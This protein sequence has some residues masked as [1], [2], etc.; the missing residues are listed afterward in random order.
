MIPVWTYIVSVVGLLVIIV[1]QAVIY[2]KK[3]RYWISKFCNARFAKMVAEGKLKRYE[4]AHAHR[5]KLKGKE[6]VE[7]RVWL[8]PK[9]HGDDYA[10][11]FKTLRQARA[12]MQGAKIAEGTKFWK[13]EEP[14]VVWKDGNVYYEARPDNL[15]A[16]AIDI[17]L[18]P[19]EHWAG[20]KKDGETK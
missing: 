13:V 19:N 5:N 18:T 2:P 12:F 1:L 15:E 8:H 20:N 4:K 9:P 11:A 7:Y 6:I 14:V 3:V 10:E 16:K 17:I